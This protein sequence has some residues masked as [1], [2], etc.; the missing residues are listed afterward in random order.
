MHAQAQQ[1]GLPPHA[2]MP[3]QMG[4]PGGMAPGFAPMPPGAG[5][6]GGGGMMYPPFAGGPIGPDVSLLP[7][8]RSVPAPISCIVSAPWYLPAHAWCCVCVRVFVARRA[9]R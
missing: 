3:M 6:G 7:I 9:C 5:G 1:Y 2:Q 8:V 4:M